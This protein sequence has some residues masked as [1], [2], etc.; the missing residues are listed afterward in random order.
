MIAILRVASGPLIGCIVAG[1]LLG[2]GVPTGPS[3][4]AGLVAW[5]AFWWV[6]ESVP[7][8]VTALLP[9][10]VIPFSGIYEKNA[11]GEACAPYADK[12]VFF[13]LGGFG[14]GLA[15][16]RTDLHR[17]G[18]LYLLRIA[19]RNG[20]NVVGAFMLATAMISMWVNNTATTML[21]QSDRRFAAP[22]LIGIAFASSIGGMATLVGT[23]PNIF[24]TSFLAK[25]GKSIDF[26]AWLYVAGPI[27]AVLLVGAWVWLVFFL[28]PVRQFQVSIP[29]DW[30]QE[31]R[32]KR[33]L[34]RDQWITLGVFLAAALTWISKEPLMRLA[35]S[36]GWG[37]LQGLLQRIEDP[38]VA[39]AALVTL[40]LVPFSKPILAWKDVEGVPWGVLMLLGGGLSL[41]KAIEASSLDQ[42]IASV[43]SHFAGLHPWLVLTLVVAIVIAISELASN[44][45]TATALIPILSDAGPAMGIDQISLLAA[46]V[47]ASSCGFMLPV[48]TPPNTLVYAQRKF[49][50]GDMIR[51]GFAV[52][53]LA[54]LTI[55]IAV[56]QL[57]YLLG[58]I[59][60]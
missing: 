30:Q 7:I 23:A 55:P 36:S 9:I 56:L 52:N 48:A 60:T 39:M 14:L 17:I 25:E 6:T 40:L 10:I 51:A 35:A 33:N 58:H 31:F 59:A 50:A 20:A 29:E 41:A 19:G 24:F 43:A 37:W 54:I 3:A 18:A 4:I 42:R 1:L 38:W 21:M 2:S 49:P 34:S 22:L 57:R 13:F 16:E 5:M 11:L 15:I 28:F 26:L 53:L 44:L 32:G 46:V 45:A 27:S 8:E 12:N 47:L